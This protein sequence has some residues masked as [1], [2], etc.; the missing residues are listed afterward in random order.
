MDTGP[1]S[2]EDLL[3]FDFSRRSLLP[4]RVRCYISSTGRDRR[5]AVGG[6]TRAKAID[7]ESLAGVVD[8]VTVNEDCALAPEYPSHGCFRILRRCKSHVSSVATYAVVETVD[9]QSPG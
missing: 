5:V 1:C 7:G 8:I 2:G 9:E 4:F 6:I 3:S